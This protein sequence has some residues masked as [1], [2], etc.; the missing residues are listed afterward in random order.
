L[1]H[2]LQ[3]DHNSMFE[4]DLPGIP[5]PVFHREQGASE[6]MNRFLENLPTNSGAKA[7][8][9]G[10]GLFDELDAVLP[11]ALVP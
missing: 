10:V 9:F 3:L 1:I 5:L 2:D 8:K 11:I 7:C 6:R 4:G